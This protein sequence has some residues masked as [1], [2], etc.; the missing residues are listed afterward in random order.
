MSA[1]TIWVYRLCWFAWFMI[2]ACAASECAHAG[3]A[4]IPVSEYV[5]DL[6]LAADLATTL[7]IRHHADYA[8]TNPVL[9][10]HPSDAKVLAYGIL[11]GVAHYGVTRGMIKLG[12]SPRL[13]DVWEGLTIGVELDMVRNNYSLGLSMRFP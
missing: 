10:R 13:I 7:D 12:A 4:Q 5:F 9:G 3:E 11:A 2:I 1:N 6:A 8:E